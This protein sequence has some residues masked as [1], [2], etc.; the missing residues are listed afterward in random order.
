MKRS[1]NHFALSLSD[2]RIPMER[3][4]KLVEGKLSLRLG[5]ADEE[6]SGAASLNFGLGPIVIH[7]D[8]IRRDTQ[9]LH[10]PDFARS[11][12]PRKLAPLEA[13][14]KEA[15]GVLPN[16]FS[17]SAAFPAP[18]DGVSF[19]IYKFASLDYTHTKFEGPQ[20]GTLFEIEGNEGR[21]ALGDEA[22]PPPTVT[23]S[24]S[25][26]IF[27]EIALDTVRLQFGARFNHQSDDSAGGGDADA[28]LDTSFLKEVA[29]LA[30]RGVVFGV[31]A[32]F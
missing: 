19:I 30:G 14:E 31:N 10:I 9:D 6:H 1:M 4:G 16:R 28:R 2:G 23:G 12:R 5:T 32:T 15:R 22:F 26:F 3:Q 20:P 11:E 24:H 7:L 8:G 18:F 27:E 29:P 21:V 17:N 13:G 25:A